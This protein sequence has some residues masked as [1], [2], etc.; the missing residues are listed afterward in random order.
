MSDK[1]PAKSPPPVGRYHV[2]HPE[3]MGIAGSSRL[4]NTKGNSSASLSSI[5]LY[6]ADQAVLA[7][8]NKLNSNRRSRMGE[9]SMRQIGSPSRLEERLTS[10][11]RSNEKVDKP[12][13]MT[14][15]ERLLS[16]GRDKPETLPPIE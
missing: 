8:R 4:M 10:P 11:G 3:T 16:G 7:S 15:R 2:D 6:N 9:Q 13:T 12:E 1:M 14:A 5:L